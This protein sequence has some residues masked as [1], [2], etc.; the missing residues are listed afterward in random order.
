MAR[1]VIQVSKEDE[2]FVIEAYKSGMTI[3][4]IENL[5]P[6]ERY[7]IFKILNQAEQAGII[8]QR[9]GETKPPKESASDK[10]FVIEAYKS[11]KALKEI[12]EKSG[13]SISMVKHYVSVGVKCGEIEEIR[14]DKNLMSKVIALYND[15]LSVKEIAE[16]VN[17]KPNAIYQRLS[18]AEKQGLV[19]KRSRETTE[20]K[21]ERIA[22]LYEQGLTFKEICAETGLSSTPVLLYIRQ[23]IEN[24]RIKARRPRKTTP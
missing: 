9:R 2:K 18:R 12:A 22:Q 3:A 10:A 24:G 4:R 6:F 15:G 8:T 21:S 17:R 11:G 19:K 16:K 5:V 1:P 14:L 13:L 7:T 20:E 23:N